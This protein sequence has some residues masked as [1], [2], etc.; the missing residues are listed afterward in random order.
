VQVNA[1][2]VEPAEVV[3]I[4]PCVNPLRVK[5]AECFARVLAD[6]VVERGEILKFF[7]WNVPVYF[8]VIEHQPRVPAVHITHQTRFRVKECPAQYAILA[9]LQVLVRVEAGS[10]EDKVLQV[11]KHKGFDAELT[12]LT[13]VAGQPGRFF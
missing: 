4:A 10:P 9:I 3:T 12:N 8:I 6:R 2:V 13:V 5:H 1:P 7:F 11:L